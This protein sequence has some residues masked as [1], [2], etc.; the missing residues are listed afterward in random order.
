MEPNVLCA[1]QKTSA[2]IHEVFHAVCNTFGSILNAL[3]HTTLDSQRRGM[4]TPQ[5]RSRCCIR[6]LCRCRVRG[7][8]SAQQH[9]NHVA[10]AGIAEGLG[11]AA[12]QRGRN[13]RSG[14]HP[15]HRLTPQNLLEGQQA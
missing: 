14:P 10:A 3:P 7:V 1:M 15:H 13:G 5:V 11:L 9:P 6:C 12:M 4:L 2:F 8:A